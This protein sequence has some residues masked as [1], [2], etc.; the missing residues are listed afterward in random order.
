MVQIDK[1]T[2]TATLK[3]LEV[4]LDDTPGLTEEEKATVQSL[5]N[6]WRLYLS[7]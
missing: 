3:W 5:V 6:F 2:A 7:F 1:Q 4:L